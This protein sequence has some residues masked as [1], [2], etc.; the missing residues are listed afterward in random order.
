MK[1]NILI[2]S[3]MLNIFYCISSDNKV[4]AFLNDTGL[5]CTLSKD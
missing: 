5:Y 4:P 2:V 1:Q 3:T